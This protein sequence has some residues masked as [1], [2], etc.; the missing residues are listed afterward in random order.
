METGEIKNLKKT[1]K[2]LNEKVLKKNYLETIKNLQEQ[3]KE[4]KS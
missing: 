2:I 1:I 3:V 4:V